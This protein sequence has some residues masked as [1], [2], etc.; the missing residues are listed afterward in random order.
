MLTLGRYL[1]QQLHSHSLYNSVNLEYTAIAES[2]G[3]SCLCSFDMRE[4][5]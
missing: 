1:P 5:D 4:R 3:P 2:P